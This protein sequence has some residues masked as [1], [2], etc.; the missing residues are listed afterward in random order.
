SFGRVDLEPV[1]DR[2]DVRR[3]RRVP[4]GLPLGRRVTPLALEGLLVRTQ[5]ARHRSDHVEE[6]LPGELGNERSVEIEDDGLVG[7]RG[8]SR[9]S[10]PYTTRSWNPSEPLPSSRW[11]PSCVKPRRSGI[12][13]LRTLSVPARITTRCTPSSPNA[14]SIKARHASVTY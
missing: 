14:M 12:A 2:L 3:D 5:L 9:S 10:S 11:T 1:A 4:A 13:R 6:V 8:H 7:Q